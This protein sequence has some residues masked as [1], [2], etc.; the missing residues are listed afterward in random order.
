MRKVSRLGLTEKI[1]KEKLLMLVK[2]LFRMI[3]V[4]ENTK[5]KL[6]P[7][8]IAWVSAAFTFLHEKRNIIYLK[9]P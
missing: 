5:I 9:C 6:L 3:K 7:F 1:G 8:D 2:P 4:I